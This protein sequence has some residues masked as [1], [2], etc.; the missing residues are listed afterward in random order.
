MYLSFQT[1]GLYNLVEIAWVNPVGYVLQAFQHFMIWNVIGSGYKDT[2]Y[3]LFT[4][5]RHR[6]DM[7]LKQ[8]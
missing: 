4:N 6:L 7:F 8:S 2:D 1:Y 3:V 5:K